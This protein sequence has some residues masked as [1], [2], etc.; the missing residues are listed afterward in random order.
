MGQ[1]VHIPNVAA[2]SDY[3]GVTMGPS[4]WVEVT[5]ERIQAFADATGD[6]Q[7]IHTNPERAHRESPFGGPIAHGYL[8]LSL[9][10][11]LID[12]LFLVDELS[13]IVNVG[14]EKMRLQEP[15]HAGQRIRLSS[16]FR[17]VRMLPSGAA[18]T[19]LHC[20]FDLEDAEKPAC[21]CDA[22]FLYFP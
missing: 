21:V 18:R 17:K 8:T 6:Q 15:V 3:I 1:P 13:M 19:S 4:R 2:I 12:E 20:V 11:P 10:P 22:V 7:W 9:A 5:Q 14:I 16:E